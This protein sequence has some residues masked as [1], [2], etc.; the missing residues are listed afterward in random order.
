MDE[1]FKCDRCDTI[2]NDFDLEATRELFFAGSREEPAEYIDHCPHCGS[3][4]YS[5]FDKCI[6]DDCTNEALPG[7][8]DCA[9]C[10]EK[11]DPQGFAEDYPAYAAANL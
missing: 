2:F 1:T 5:D 4:D 11:T 7:C 8:D 9:A 10:W 3:E 6:T